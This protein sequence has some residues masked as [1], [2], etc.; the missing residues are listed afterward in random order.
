MQRESIQLARK[1]RIPALLCAL[2]VP[3]CILLGTPFVDMSVSDDAPYI[4][5][6]QH[7]S[8]TG[9]IVYNGWPAPILGWQLY[10]GAAFIKLFGFSFTHV[11]MSTWLVGAVMAFVLQ[12]ALVAGNI[13][14]RNATIGTLAFVVS[15]LYIL[16]SATYMTD[17]Y[18]LFAIVICIYG[19]LKALKASSDGCAD[20]VIIGWLC[21]AVATNAVF[22]TARQLGW[23]GI[24]ILL[25][26]TLWLLRARRRVLVAGIVATLLGVV[27]ILACVHWFSQQPYGQHEAILLNPFPLWRPAYQLFRVYMGLPF[28]LLPIMTLFLPQVRRNRPR[29][30]AV[31][32]VP[33]FV[34][35]FLA[36]F[37]SHLRGDFQLEPFLGDWVEEHGIYGFIELKGKMPMFL[38]GGERDVL[39]FACIGGLIGLLSALWHLRGKPPVTVHPSGVTWRQFSVLLVPYLIVYTLLLVPRGVHVILP[40]RYAL[41]MLPVLVFLLVRYYQDRISPRL[42]WAGYALVAFMGAYSVVSVHNWFALYRARVVLAAEMRAAGFPDTSVD[43]GWEYN[44]EVEIKQNGYINDPRIAIPKDAYKVVGPP[45]PGPCHARWY[46]ATPH[47]HPVFGVSFVPNACYG[48]AP[49][50]PVHYDRWLAPSQGTLYVVKYTKDSPQP[51]AP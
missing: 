22:G 30:V 14:E 29:T 48:P 49:F 15:P 16:L 35:L 8:E 33:G 13:S 4:R 50:A 36:T 10:I 12:R 2:A 24:F 31:I 23:M 43:N 38:N 45:P 18:G 41:G 1:F 39:T 20:R 28:L 7:L 34:Y 32:C 11:R 19:C 44:Y 46:D 9:H 27:F 42:P 5:I 17:I 37:P 40:D 47:V 26:C 3:V 21:F 6:A 25:P 51:P